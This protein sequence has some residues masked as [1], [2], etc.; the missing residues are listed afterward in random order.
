[1]QRNETVE[2]NRMMSATWVMLATLLLISSLAA[3]A[4]GVFYAVP[5]ILGLSW[6]ALL[7]GRQRTKRF[8]LPLEKYWYLMRWSGVTVALL[9]SVGSMFNGTL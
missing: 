1:M 6:I 9:A 5:S 3:I 7:M 4:D 8:A 2:A